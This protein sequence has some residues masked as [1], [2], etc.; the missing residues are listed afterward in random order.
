MQFHSFQDYLASKAHKPCHNES[1]K[2]L[3]FKLDP[4]RRDCQSC[5]FSDTLEEIPGLSYL[6]CTNCGK[7]DAQKQACNFEYDD[8]QGRK[9]VI[10]PRQLQ[11]ALP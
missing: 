3:K 8:L 4:K 9:Q 1:S 2:P 6:C 11:S 10:Q 7:T 5:G